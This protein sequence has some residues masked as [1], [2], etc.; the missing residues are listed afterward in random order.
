MEVFV[1]LAVVALAAYVVFRLTGK[2]E[3]KAITREDAHAILLESGGWVEIMD[4]SGTQ[5]FFVGKMVGELEESGSILLVGGMV[6]AN[7][8]EALVAA[9]QKTQP[10]GLQDGLLLA[11]CV[12]NPADDVVLKPSG[13][14]QARS[15]ITPYLDKADDIA[16]CLEMSSAG[17]AFAEDDEG[18][19]IFNDLWRRRMQLPELERA[20][21]Q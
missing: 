5:P 19:Q 18:M 11:R 1:F 4:A 7:V 6:E 10:I 8:P 12:T 15:A 16:L 21:P 2:T 17:I 14:S 20:S 9:V 3:S 13:N